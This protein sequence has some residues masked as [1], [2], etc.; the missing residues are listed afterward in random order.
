MN[1][2][3]FSAVDCAVIA[4]R[5][6]F[7]YLPDSWVKDQITLNNNLGFPNSK[8]AQ[9]ASRYNLYLFDAGDIYCNQTKTHG[10]ILIGEY[11]FNIP[12]YAPVMVESVKDWNDRDIAGCAKAHMITVPFHVVN[13]IAGVHAVFVKVTDVIFESPLS[14]S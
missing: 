10:Y 6:L 1:D 7:G 4:L 12:N 9:L 13:S 11:K 3:G 5:D 8:N 2:S 14:V